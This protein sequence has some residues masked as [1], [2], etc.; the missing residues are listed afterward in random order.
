MGLEGLSV[1]VVNSSLNALK[2]TLLNG[3]Y[4][5]YKAEVNIIYF[6]I[7][8]VIPDNVSNLSCYLALRVEGN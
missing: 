1:S 8:E 6:K 3:N 5:Y 7:L 2:L 4:Q